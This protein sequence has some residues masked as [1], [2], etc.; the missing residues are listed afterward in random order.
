MS[1]GRRRLLTSQR[2]RV[3]KGPTSIRSTAASGVD[4]AVESW[5]GVVELG[6]TE[7]R[8]GGDLATNHVRRACAGLPGKPVE[9]GDA[10]GVDEL[11]TTTVAMISRRSRC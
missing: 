6:S 5:N 8:P 10:R 7:D 3:D 4:A 1:D 9:A 2:W 11:F